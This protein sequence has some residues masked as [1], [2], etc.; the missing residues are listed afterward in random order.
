MASWIPVS[1]TDHRDPSPPQKKT[2]A[3]FPLFQNGVCCVRNVG[4]H[5]EDKPWIFCVVVPLVTQVALETMS[6][7]PQLLNQ[8][9]DF[10]CVDTGVCGDLTD[11]K[12][13]EEEQ[14]A[15]QQQKHH[16]QQQ[17][18]WLFRQCHQA[19]WLSRA[20]SG[21]WG[22]MFVVG[23]ESFSVGYLQEA[24]GRTVTYD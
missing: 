13:K 20:G 5:L 4:P 1:N 23:N 9:E 21:H 18:F 2:H 8:R 22:L 19:S 12:R 11:L 10:T 24:C 17:L 14:R 15:Q 16:Q 6:S 7:S 3:R